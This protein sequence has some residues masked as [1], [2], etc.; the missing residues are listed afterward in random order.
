M[1]GRWKLATA[2]A[3]LVQVVAAPGPKRYLVKILSRPA[4]LDA[5]LEPAIPDR[6][7]HGVLH[8]VDG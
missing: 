7:L 6:P 3:H 1:T 4:G 8:W 2:F 5:N